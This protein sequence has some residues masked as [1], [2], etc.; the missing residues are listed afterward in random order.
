MANLPI[1]LAGTWDPVSAF[2]H[3]AGACVGIAACRDAKRLEIRDPMARGALLLYCSAAITVLLASGV[4]HLTVRG[5]F[6]RFLLQRLDHAAIFVLIAATFTPVHLILFRGR[7]RW[8]PI[9]SIW[10]LALTG[11]AVKML[12]FS[13][14][15][16]W[17]GIWL[18]LGLA[19]LGLISVAILARRHGVAFVIPLI[20][21]SACYF[22]G[23]MFELSRAPILWPGYIGPHELLHLS[24]LLAILLHWRFMLSIVTGGRIAAEPQPSAITLPSSSLST[25]GGVE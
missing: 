18:Y 21:G 8:M 6:A 7:L 23:A 3:L 25:E 2:T 12:Y 16:S 9:V 24:V 1:Q 4:Y 22:A 17:A 11:L 13:A 19:G 10:F 14:I 5:S 15:P 20:A